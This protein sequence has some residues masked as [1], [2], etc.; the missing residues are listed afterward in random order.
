VAVSDTELSGAHIEAGDKVAMYFASGNRD[1]TQFD[2]P[3]RFIV[4]RRPNNHMAFGKGG[5]HFCLGTHVARLQVRIL[6]E[7]MRER[8]AAIELTGPA[9]R[10]RSNHVHGIK[11]LPARFLPC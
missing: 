6:L 11:R 1:E 10:L 2:D 3:H 7:Q 9:D 5:P 8:V 4:D